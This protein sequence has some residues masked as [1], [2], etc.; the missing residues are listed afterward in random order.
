MPNDLPIHKAASNGDDIELEELLE[1]GE[2]VNARGAGDRVPLH[3]AVG[4]G[5]LKCARLLLDAKAN[6]CVKDA[7]GRTPLHWAAIGGQVECIDL[8]LHIEGVDINA[9]SNTGWTPLHG[10]ASGGK[11]DAV[12]FLIEAGADK[13]ATDSENKTA[14]EVMKEAGYK[15]PSILKVGSE[16]SSC[17]KFKNPFGTM[18]KRTQHQNQ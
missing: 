18:R 1:E 7:A 8:L 14:F 2:D 12:A 6:P 15:P 11:L 5:H 9:Q 4:A 10:A 16:S 13:T 17:S 3:R